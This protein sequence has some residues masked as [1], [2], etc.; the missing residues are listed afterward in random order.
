MRSRT[1]LKIDVPST[2]ALQVE[3]LSSCSSSLSTDSISS[4]TSTSSSSCRFA[5]TSFRIRRKSWMAVWAFIV[6]D[7][8]SSVFL[9][10]GESALV[11]IFEGQKLDVETHQPKAKNLEA[12]LAELNT[13]TE[14]ATKISQNRLLQAS[15]LQNDL[16]F[17]LRGRSSSVEAAFHKYQIPDSEWWIDIAAIEQDLVSDTGC[18]VYSFGIGT[19]DSYTNFMA[20]KGCQVFAFDPTQQHPLAWKPNI[21]FYS[22]G[23]RNSQDTQD[24]GWS[25]PKYGNLTGYLFSLPEIVAKLGHQGRR[26]SA[27]KFDCEGCEY[28][29]F[30][31]IVN[32]EQATREKFN[33]IGSLSTEFHFST[34]L[35]MRT[36][37]DVA[38]IQY[39]NTFLQSQDCRVIH[40]KPNRGF[41]KDRSVHPFLI[42]HGV[43]NGTCCYEYG[44][45]CGRNRASKVS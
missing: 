12:M 11:Y 3:S 42:E 9:L 36:L 27:L 7:L 24:L 2:E 14:T 5:K 40:Y 37:E 30:Q 13:G 43:V 33:P 8:V 35:G 31:D 10:K 28:G 1:C 38:N 41:K 32:F 34:T 25:H 45:S 22:W 29:A 23:I 26:I 18:L 21:S 20:Q 6:L 4:P 16:S 44:F 19:D 17:S 15:V 39:T